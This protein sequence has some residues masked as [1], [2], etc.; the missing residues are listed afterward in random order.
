MADCSTHEECII[1]QEIGLD[2]VSTTLC[3]DTDYSVVVNGQNFKLIE[4]LQKTLS[5]QLIAE[6]KINNPDYIR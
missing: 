4:K 2:C 5:I 3:G 1:T 6:G